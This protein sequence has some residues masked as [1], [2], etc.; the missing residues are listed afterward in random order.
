MYI[1]RCTNCGWLPAGDTHTAVLASPGR[2]G[3]LLVSSPGAAT[4]HCAG[5][6]ARW[7]PSAGREQ[8]QLIQQ[9]GAISPNVSAHAALLGACMRKDV[10]QLHGM[11]IDGYRS[12]QQ[13]TYAMQT[14]DVHAQML[15]P[16][17]AAVDPR[18][19]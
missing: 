1:I 19:C 16:V 12:Q 18:E 5:P 4:P 8:R 11:L 13:L 7:W 3:L 6:H 10:Q 17:T 14:Y 15:C 2:S 9:P